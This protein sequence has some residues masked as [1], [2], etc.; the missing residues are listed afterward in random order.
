MSQRQWK[1]QIAFIHDENIGLFHYGSDHPMKPFRLNLTYGL[2]LAYGMHKH[3]SV[4]KPSKASVSDLAK[5]H[6]REYIELLKS[7]ESLPAYSNLGHKHAAQIVND[8]PAFPGLYEYCLMY[9]GASLAGARLLSDKSFDIAINWS[10]GLHHAKKSQPSGF[11]YVNDIVLAICELLQYFQR[12]LYIDIDV[13]HGDGV[14]EAFYLTDRVMTVSFH[15]YGEGFFPGTGHMLQL[16]VNAGKFFSLN[17][18]LKEGMDDESY[19]DLF[20]P[21]MDAVRQRYRPEAVVLQCGA[22]SLG[23]DR[24]GRFSLSIRGHGEFSQRACTRSRCFLSDTCR[25]VQLKYEQENVSA[26]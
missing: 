24:L 21:I 12:V 14:Q 6:S 15:R 16:G 17:V 9:T 8:C 18:P 22:D 5:F 11:C 26:I 7:S 13:H 25:S 1:P 23:G 3:M 20:K 19:E 10:G 2:V 4:Y